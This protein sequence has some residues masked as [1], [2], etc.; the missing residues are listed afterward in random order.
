MKERISAD[1]FK[2]EL[3]AD[4]FGLASLPE[5][6]WRPKLELSS[7]ELTAPVVSAEQPE[8]LATGE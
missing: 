4:N 8:E 7:S 2:H 6:V 1:S 5:E 3:V